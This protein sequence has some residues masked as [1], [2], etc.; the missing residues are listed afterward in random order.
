M[1]GGHNLGE[2]VIFSSSFFRAYR[3]F[4]SIKNVFMPP[5]GSLQMKKTEI[6]CFFTKLRG[7]GG[8]PKPNYF[9]VFLGDFFIALK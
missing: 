6:V 1:V 5:K 2:N 3:S 9:R 4:K 7:G 8:N